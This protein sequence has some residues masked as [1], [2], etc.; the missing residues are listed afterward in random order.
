MLSALAQSRSR[1]NRNM[2]K[3]E[4]QRRRRLRL[5]LLEASAVAAFLF[6]MALLSLRL[7]SS[8]GSTASIAFAILAAGAAYLLADVATGTVHWFCDTF[9]EETTPLIGPLI[10]APF[11]EHHT[12]PLAMTRHGFLELTGNSCLA[13]APVL[14]VALWLGPRDENSPASAAFYSFVVA[15]AVS[16]GATN[17]FHR[18][19]HEPVPPR[20]VKFLQ[21]CGLI[22]PA[23]R[24]AQHHEAPHASAYCVANGWA[25]PLLDRIGFFRAVERLLIGLGLPRTS[26]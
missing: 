4:V 7:V 20:V 26:N 15:F 10:I 12:D 17:L 8:L 18:W 3:P 2:H 16:A 21:G 22:L 1:Y 24:H 11:R 14:G 23:T 19:A 5:T 6:L 9:F 25:N 13:L